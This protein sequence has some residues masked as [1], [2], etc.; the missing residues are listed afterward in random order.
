MD[1][2]LS[3]FSE[4][5]A[6][7]DYLVHVDLQALG[8][9]VDERIIDGLQ[10]G[11][12]QKFEY[13]TELCWKSLKIFLKT[14]EGIDEASPKKVV[15]A[16]YLESFLVEE[17]YLLLIQAIDDRNRL[18]HVYDKQDFFEILTRLASYAEL[19]KRILQRLV[20]DWKE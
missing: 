19:F 10:N 18:S 3:A 8:A 2:R 7:F 4:A 11:M 14:H 16:C 17:D 13:T 20:S 5:V 6:G 15:K 1:V 12:V 9:Q